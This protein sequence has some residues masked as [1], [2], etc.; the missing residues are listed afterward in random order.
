MSIPGARKR[1][2]F[3]P[4]GAFARELNRRV[5]Q[6]MEEEG[7]VRYGDWSQWLRLGFIVLVGG[8]AYCE[9][10]RQ[11]SGLWVHIAAVMIAALCAFLLILQFGHDA[12]HGSI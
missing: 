6:A 11:S 12:S 2:E 5:K 9:M 4:P 3:A 7:E 8:I 10:L 1:L